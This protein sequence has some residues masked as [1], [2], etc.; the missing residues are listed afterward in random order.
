MWKQVYE[1]GE[2]RN[3]TNLNDDHT[4]HKTTSFSHHIF[5]DS[6]EQAVILAGKQ[7]SISVRHLAAI[8]RMWILFMLFVWFIKL[9]RNSICSANKTAISSAFTCKMDMLCIKMIFINL[10]LNHGFMCCTIWKTEWYHYQIHL[11]QY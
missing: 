8:E 11:S 5:R 7:I 4:N 9:K 6:R 10:Y 2:K 3:V 1:L